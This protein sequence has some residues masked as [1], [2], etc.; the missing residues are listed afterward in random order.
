MKRAIV[1]G[2]RLPTDRVGALEALGF[3]VVNGSAAI[4]A[5]LG[6]PSTERELDEQ[7]I[8]AALPGAAVYIYGG[9]E[10]ANEVVLE[11]ADKLELIVFLGT[12]WSD[13]GC[14][15]PR[16]ARRLGI[17]VANTPYAN[18]PSA[19]EMTMGLLLAL[20]RAIVSMNNATKAGGWTPVRRRDLTG[21]RLGVI[22]LGHIGSRVA[23]H[24]AEGFEMEVVYSSPR[25]KPELEKRLA[26]RRV[27]LE[28]LLAT[29]DYIS[30]HTPVD[31][32][33]GLVTRDLLATVKPESLLVN[34]SGPEVVDG[35][36]LCDAL[37][38]GMLRGAALDGLYSEPEELRRRLLDL[39]D[40]KLIVLP[41]AAWLTDDSYERMSD[42]ALK[43]LSDH[44]AGLDPIANQV[45][46]R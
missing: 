11:A 46:P 27:D 34:I 12:G 6:R 8:R 41:R 29:S 15:D 24:A 1:T 42:M 13:P 32:T 18:A 19:A 33:R 2:S 17:R 4:L 14:V 40:D 3:E 36:A 9:L 23:R 28:D 7:E 30:I 38:E 25:A 44:V 5:E 35:E 39:G 45:S 22:G 26:C 20:E 16:A 31:A 43:S 37:S 21:R 10:P